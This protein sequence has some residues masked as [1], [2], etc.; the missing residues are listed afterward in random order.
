M[1]ILV[2]AFTLILIARIFYLQILNDSFKLKAENN[3]I[4]IEY[5]IPER[6][7]IYDRNGKLLVTNQTS[8]DIMVVPREVK[9][10]DTLELCKLLGISKNEFFKKITK[11]KKFSTRLPSL[12]LDQLD[13]SE[14]SAF[15]EK[16]RKF[17]G[18]YFQK[19]MLRN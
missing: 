17:Q 2:I 19:R 10:I 9:N 4:K 16:I 12:F 11:A 18:F 13:H 3:S 5:E 14:F 8:Y 15:Q 7:N 6:G 1:P